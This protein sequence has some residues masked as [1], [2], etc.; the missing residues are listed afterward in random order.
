[1]WSE[2]IVTAVMGVSVVFST[3]II[4]AFSVKLMSFCCNF[5]WRKQKKTHGTESVLAGT[6]RK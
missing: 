1:M 4:L 3:L 2:A 6:A 5:K